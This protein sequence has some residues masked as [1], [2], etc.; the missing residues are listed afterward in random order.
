VTAGTLTLYYWNELLGNT[1]FSLGAA[2]AATDTT[3]TLSQAGPATAGSFI[4]IE[5]EVL[6]VTA[7]QNGGLQYTVTR[8]MQGTTPA[9]YPAQTPVYHL[10]SMVTVVPFPLDFFGSPLSGMWSYPVLLPNVRV[11]SGELFVTNSRGNSSMAS[12]NLTQSVDYG[13][14]TLSGGQFSI[15][16]QGFLAVDS[17]PA[18][19]VVVEAAHAVEDVYAVVKQAPVGSPIQLTLSQNGTTYCTLTIPDGATSS[20]AVDGFG[21]P[22]QEQAQLS[23]AITAVGETSPGSDLTVIIRL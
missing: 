9:A 2:M 21:M 3:L 11:A 5:A 4:Q 6:Q 15:Q 17:D 23:L 10:L 12:A 18:P 13:L 22:L 14:R 8:G 16:V 20:L 19:N 1:P 7:T